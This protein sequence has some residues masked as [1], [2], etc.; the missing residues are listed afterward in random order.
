[1]SRK[2]PI[3]A[4][5]KSLYGAVKA[6]ARAQ[7]RVATKTVGRALRTMNTSAKPLRGSGEWTAGIAFG[8][9][10]TRR[11]QLLKPPGI[12]PSE[13]LPLIVML[14]GCGQ[15]AKAFALSTRMN[16]IAVQE[17]FLALYPEQDR[18]ANLQGCWN[19]YD[20]DSRRAYR[21]AATIAAAIDQ[22]CLLQPVDASRIAGAGLS[23]G[24]S[25]AALLASRDPAR[26][27]AVAMHS[28]IPPG[29]AH[30]SVSALRAMRGGA[31]N[32]APETG[33][34]SWPPLLVI[35]GSADHVVAAGNGEAAAEL[36]AAAAGARRS[37]SR[38]VRRG[39]RRAMT[40][41]DFE[42]QGRTVATLCLVDGL[43]HAWSG[44]AAGQPFSDAKGPDA[45]RMIWSFA[46]RQFSAA[47]RL[48]GVP[49]QSPCRR[50]GAQPLE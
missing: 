21:E 14:H 12:K 38:I 47:A 25:M 42:R 35:H 4:W 15:D 48:H 20:T 23:A 8:P 30:S 19:W 43:G 6:L 10:G 44:G 34:A 41:T 9:A 37:A 39:H 16:R 33:A 18:R 11:F 40:V 31:T 49:D 2:H 27:Q 24:A 7:T 32:S 17:R 29:S 3:P 28:G 1:M 45:S 50:I 36:W 46:A 5:S 13:R 22:V 26:V